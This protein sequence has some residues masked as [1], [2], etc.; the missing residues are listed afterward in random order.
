MLWKLNLLYRVETLCQIYKLEFT[1]TD[2]FLFYDFVSV[3][4]QKN[5][6]FH[7][8][9][10]GISIFQNNIEKIIIFYFDLLTFDSLR[11]NIGKINTIKEYI[12][13]K[14]NMI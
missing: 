9:S 8:I 2:N 5:I 11:I 7:E 6:C 13:L 14:L 12:S 3:C 10:F 1:W 4:F